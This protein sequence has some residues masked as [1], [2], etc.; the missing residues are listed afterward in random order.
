MCPVCRL[1]VYCFYFVATRHKTE[2]VNQNLTNRTLLT[3]S[4]SLDKHFSS[5][6]KGC[7]NF[8]SFYIFLIFTFSR[9]YLHIIIFRIR[10]FT[11]SFLGV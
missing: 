8:L 11:Q 9:M 6:W 10:I 1:L 7:P 2:T 4:N 3:I 5:A